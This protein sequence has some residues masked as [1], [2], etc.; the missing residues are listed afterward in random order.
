[1]PT[2]SA[3]EALLCELLRGDTDEAGRL[4]PHAIMAVQRGLW[5]LPQLLTLRGDQLPDTPAVEIIL[6]Y[7]VTRLNDHLDA[8]RAAVPGSPPE[9]A[10]V[11]AHAPLRLPL[12]LDGTAMHAVRSLVAAGAAVPTKMLHS[13]EVAGAAAHQASGVHVAAFGTVGAS[14]AATAAWLGPS[15]VHNRET[16]R[17]YLEAL[18]DRSGGPV[19]S[20]IPITI[21]ERAWVLASLHRAGIDVDVPGEII[22]SLAHSIGEQGTPG[23]AGLPPDA[24]TTAVTL[25]ALSNV[26]IR[27]GL[28]CLGVYETDTHFCTWM[29]ERTA[30]TTTNAHVL[31]VIMHDAT[32]AEPPSSRHVTVADKLT[33]WLLDQQSADG[34]WLD[35]WHAS[36]YYA[37]AECV[38]AL[39]GVSRWADAMA[40]AYG[41]ALGSVARRG[42]EQ[43]IGWL[44]ETQRADG[45]WGRWTGTIEETAYG[46]RAILPALATPAAERALARGHH[47][48]AQPREAAEDPPMW[49]DKDLY[50]PGAVV[51]AAVLA[52]KVLAGRVPAVQAHAGHFT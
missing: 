51:S 10:D 41:A 23:G 15:I 34:F 17:H 14:P 4:R 48:L 37:T 20:V 7:L 47:F 19:P 30:S 43:A 28:D 18:V 39:A 45:S 16:S 44:L 2:L 49:H 26:G 46:L 52:A 42:I 21:F 33:R 31:D 27:P 50:L 32:G 29:G 6:P 38:T 1:V 12:G 5:A 8:A 9:L 3:T 24:D 13:L 40:G 11:A 35:K 36:P 25:L 22:D